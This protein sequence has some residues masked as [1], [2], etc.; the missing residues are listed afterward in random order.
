MWKYLNSKYNDHIESY[1]RT[2][3]DWYFPVALGS[4][5]P[6]INIHQ[7]AHT[8]THT[9]IYIYIYIYIRTHTH[10]CTCECVW[11][12]STYFVCNN[13]KRAR[14][15]FPKLSP[16]HQMVKCH[17]QGTY[18][19]GQSYHSAE[20]QSAYSIDLRELGREGNFK[21]HFCELSN[22]DKRFDRYVNIRKLYPLCQTMTVKHEVAIPIYIYIYIYIY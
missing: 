7:H 3:V 1:L 18:G 10:I 12:V 14:A 17:T 13:T 4:V 19:D 8:H 20:M 22:L 9:H 11:F 2:N 16:L 5:V 15:E 6:E 21:R